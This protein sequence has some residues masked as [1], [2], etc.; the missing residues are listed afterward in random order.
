S[1]LL[2]VT[3]WAIR[4]SL[5]SYRFTSC[6]KA[7]TSP[8]LLAWT[9]SKS[10]SAPVLTANCAESGVIKFQ[11][12]ENDSLVEAIEAARKAK[13]LPFQCRLEVAASLHHD[14]ASHLR[15]D[16]AVIGIRPRL[17]KCVGERFVCI[18]HLGLEHAV[19]AH[20]RMRNIIMIDPCNRR[21]DWYRDRL[22]S[23]TEIIDFYFRV[24]RCGLVSRRDAG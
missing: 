17:G 1:S 18:P 16:R 15:V 19:C 23:K 7:A 10:S 3:L 11:S 8:F 6:S 22:G 9:R 4:R 2:W 12:V 24:R 20:H 13:P 5:R 21:S 14:L